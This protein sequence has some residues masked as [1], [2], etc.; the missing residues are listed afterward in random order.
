MKE[1][2]LSVGIDVGTS[3]TQLIF[4]NIY[5]ENVSSMARVPEFRIVG[6]DIIYKSNIHRTPLTSATV[7]NEDALTRMIQAEYENA[8]IDPS[9]VDS[10]A[11]IITGETARKENAQSVMSALSGLAGEFVVATA[12]PDLEGIIAGR[13]S[14]VAS[15]SDKENITI[16]NL[17][18]GGGT[19]NTGVFHV[20]EPIDTACFDIGG[21]LIIIDESKTITYISEK[22]QELCNYHGIDLKVGQKADLDKLKAI[23]QVMANVLLSSVH[24]KEEDKSLDLAI[25]PKGKK[26]R[27]DYKIDKISFTGGVSQYIYNPSKDTDYFIYNDIGPLLGQIIRETFQPYWDKIVVPTET[28]M[29]TVVGAGT[30]TMDISGSTVTYTTMDFPKKNLPVL[31]FTESEQDQSNFKNLILDKLK[32]FEMEDGLQQVA[33]Y[34]PG[35]ENM[36]YLEVD[37]FA[38]NIVEAWE[39]VYKNNEDIIVILKEDLGKVLGQCIRARLSNKNRAVICLDSIKVHNGDYIDIGHPLGNGSVLPVVI[40]TLV[41]NY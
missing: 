27:N 33:M 25:S 23:C 35:K 11:V 32:W 15:L 9:K 37:E 34:F 5:V 31:A 28:I 19:T 36:S 12:G 8:N 1:T 16:A 20:G 24:L 7:I 4:S 38:G 17:D 40:K 2:L 14:G 10:G 13:G 21:R 3:T 6:K 30:Q 22:V 41:L 39:S 29:A 18:I 26:L